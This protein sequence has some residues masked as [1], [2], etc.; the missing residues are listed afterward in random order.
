MS[1]FDLYSLK[2]FLIGSF[3]TYMLMRNTSKK[4][5]VKEI[6]FVRRLKR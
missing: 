4:E 2:A 3:V 6:E 1:Q 5:S